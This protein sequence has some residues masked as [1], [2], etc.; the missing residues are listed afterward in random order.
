VTGGP[1]QTDDRLKRREPDRKGVSEMDSRIDVITLA[2][3]ELERALAFHRDGLGLES[4]GDSRTQ[5]HP[6]PVSSGCG[7]RLGK[8]AAD[9]IPECRRWPTCQCCVAVAFAKTV[10]RDLIGAWQLA[11]IEVCPLAGRPQ[12]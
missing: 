6:R 4:R 7:L 9:S 12:R 8:A 1:P 5:C 10:E 3:S 2:V 11:S